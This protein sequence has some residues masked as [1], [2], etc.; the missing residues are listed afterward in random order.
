LGSKLEQ[1]DLIPRFQISKSDN[2]QPNI[3]RNPPE[4]ELAIHRKQVEGM[5]TPSQVGD[6]LE[7]E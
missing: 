5:K 1:L 7:D 2:Q 4:I 3:S 6:A